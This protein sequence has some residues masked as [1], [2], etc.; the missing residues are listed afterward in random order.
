MKK[1]IKYILK[2]TLRIAKIPKSFKKNN[3]EHKP[4]TS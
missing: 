4:K 1:N 3:P 2:F